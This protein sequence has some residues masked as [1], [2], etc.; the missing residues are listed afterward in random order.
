MNKTQESIVKG[1]STIELPIVLPAG[2]FWIGMAEQ[3][4]VEQ[5]IRD[6][7]EMEMDYIV[8][9]YTYTG[10]QLLE[11]LD[12]EVNTHEYIIEDAEIAI[13]EITTRIESTFTDEEVAAMRAKRVA[14][15]EAWREACAKRQNDA[16]MLINIIVEHGKT[17]KGMKYKD[18]GYDFEKAQKNDDSIIIEINVGM[19]IVGKKFAHFVPFVP[20]TKENG[21]C[22]EVVS[23]PRTALSVEEKK[24]LKSIVK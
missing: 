3:A 19:L 21:S 1:S 15:T 10:E 23:M 12:G 16:I 18:A 2:R 7:E 14:A 20:Y 22:G 11:Y 13:E 17:L 5:M 24:I 8:S 6:G 9:E 4:E